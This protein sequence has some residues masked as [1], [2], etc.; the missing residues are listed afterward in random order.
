MEHADFLKKMETYMGKD[1]PPS[2]FDE[3]WNKQIASLPE[4]IPYEIKPRHFGAENIDFFDLYF[5]VLMMEQF[6]LSVF[7]LI[8]KKISQLY[9]IFMATWVKHQI[10]LAF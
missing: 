1:N 2:D 7:S 4:S 8:I 6:M 10:G 3:F 5:K 9:F